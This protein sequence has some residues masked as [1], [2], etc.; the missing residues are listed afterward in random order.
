MGIV[1]ES[2]FY[3]KQQEFETWMREVKNLPDFNGPKWELMDHFKSY[4]EDF[5]TCTFPS[6][7]FYNLAKWEMEEVGY[8]TITHMSWLYIFFL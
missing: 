2:D 7:K 1:R 4:C 8:R 6:P 3:T 5:N